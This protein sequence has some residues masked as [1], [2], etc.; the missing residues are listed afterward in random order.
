[1]NNEELNLRAKNARRKAIYRT[2]TTKNYERN[3]F[4]T[5]YAK[6]WAKGRCQLCEKPAPYRNKRAE[7]HL[8]IHHI[9]WLSRGGEDSIYNTVALCPNCHDKMH[10]LDLKEDIMKLKEVLARHFR[11]NINKDKK[12][13]F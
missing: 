9:D 3:P 1:M 6:R 10:V 11:E 8:H 5:E 13:L 2:V 4:V 7:P 12:A